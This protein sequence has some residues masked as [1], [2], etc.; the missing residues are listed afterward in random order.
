MRYYFAYGSNLRDEKISEICPNV[1]HVS[2]GSVKGYKFAFRGTSTLRPGSVGTILKDPNRIVQGF[3][4][5]L[6]D[7][8]I[9]ALDKWEGCPKY[10]GKM[11]VSV[12]TDEGVLNCFTYYKS[13]D[14]EIISPPNRSYLEEVLRGYIEKRLDPQDVLKAYKESLR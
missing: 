6:C 13:S 14:P 7:E 8:E 4:Y 3:V 5:L 2:Q 10:Y 12:E 11:E 1:R 9:P